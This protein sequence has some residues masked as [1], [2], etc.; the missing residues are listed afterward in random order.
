MNPFSMFILAV[1]AYKLGIP[2]EYSP[3]SPSRP[4]SIHN[5][6]L[7]IITMFRL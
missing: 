6:E 5:L 7:S 1:P 4:R 2:T 3:T